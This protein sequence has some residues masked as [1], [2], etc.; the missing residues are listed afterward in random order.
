M[1]GGP[2]FKNEK[3]SDSSGVYKGRNSASPGIVESLSDF[4][5][6]WVALLPPVSLL[7]PSHGVLAEMLV[8]LLTILGAVC[9]GLVVAAKSSP[10]GLVAGLA[11]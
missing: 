9:P 11:R 8:S 3:I 6:W 7:R 4:L 2:I 10:S 5:D 1:T